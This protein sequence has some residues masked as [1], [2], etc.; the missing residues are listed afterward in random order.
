MENKKLYTIKLNYKTFDYQL[1]KNYKTFFIKFFQ[2]FMNK[3][4]S[5]YD[6]SLFLNSNSKNIENLVFFN[7]KSIQL[8]TNHKN[9]IATIRSPHIF[10]ISQEHFKKVYYKF[11]IIISLD[12]ELHKYIE[13]LLYKFLINFIEKVPNGLNLKTNYTKK[14]YIV[15]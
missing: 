11:K 5:I 15:L 3:I 1:Y 9:K 12:I 10:N 13:K 6:I 4:F 8:P 7:I 2:N 14:K